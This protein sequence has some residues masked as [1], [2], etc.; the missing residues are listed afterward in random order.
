MIKINN[1]ESNFQV[2]LDTR[3]Y[4]PDQVQVK[5][6]SDGMLSI[7]GKHEERSDDGRK[8]ISRQFTR[9][10][11]LPKACMP[12]KLRSYWSPDGVLAVTAPKNKAPYTKEV[13]TVTKKVAFS[14]T[15]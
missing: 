1:D 8:H 6:Q 5:I 7:E 4:K 12:N 13:T 9:K 3:H 14:T 11:S 2:I 10:Y 15:N